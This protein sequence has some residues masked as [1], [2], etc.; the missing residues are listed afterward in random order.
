MKRLFLFAIP[1]LLTIGC[2][3]Q[4]STEELVVQ[5]KAAD[6]S[7]RLQAMRELTVR[8]ADAPVMVPVLTDALQDENPYVRRDAARALRSFGG[9][10]RPAVPAL[11]TAARD[12]EPSVRRAAINALREI[13]PE[14]A[15][16]K[17]RVK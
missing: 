10:A 14:T 1:L 6:Q 7:A 3:R 12:R 4:K 5:A 13:D 11:L 15:T 16:R 8:S 9:D 17:L 2:A